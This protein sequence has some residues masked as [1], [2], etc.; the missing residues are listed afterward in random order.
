[1]WIWIFFG[2]IW[3]FIKFVLWWVLNIWVLMGWIFKCR[4]VR[5]CF[6][7]CLVW[8]KVFWWL[9]KSVKLL[10]YC[11]YFLICN[12]FLIKWLKLFKKKLVK[13]WL[14]RLF[15]GRFFC[16]SMGV[17]GLFFGKYFSI[18][19]WGLLLL[20][21]VLIN[22]NVFWYLIFW[23]ILV[24]RIFRLILGKYFW[25]LYCRIYLLEWEKLIKCCR[26]WWEL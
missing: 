16:W 10:M 2:N 22:Y 18:G 8:V 26:V 15:M 9:L 12:F 7:F 25:M 5:F 17:V 6:I 3:K 4:V 11:K 24:L 23:W 14:V 21:I 19:F 1:M 13:N 20:I